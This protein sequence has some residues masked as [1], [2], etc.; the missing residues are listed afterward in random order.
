MTMH[1]TLLLLAAMLL[2]LSLSGGE[3]ASETTRVSR[4]VPHQTVWW[5]RHL[6]P[7]KL[8]E[9]GLSVLAGD[10]FEA[11]SASAKPGGKE[12][13]AIPENTEALARFVGSVPSGQPEKQ[14]SPLFAGRFKNTPGGAGPGPGSGPAPND[15]A[16]WSVDGNYQVNKHIYETSRVDPEGNTPFT[17]Q[18]DS[19]FAGIATY[20]VNVPLAGNTTGD[21]LD[22]C[23]AP[24][25]KGG[26]GS[27]IYKKFI[28]KFE[29]RGEKPAAVNNLSDPVNSDSNMVRRSVYA[30]YSYKNPHSIL[31]P[32]WTQFPRN[33]PAPK[34]GDP[35]A[36]QPSAAAQAQWNQFWNALLVHE[37]GHKAIFDAALPGV[38]TA[39]NTFDK[40]L[41]I[42]EVCYGPG[43]QTAA[44]NRALELA[45]ALRQSEI[46]A[47]VAAV[48]ALR[49]AHEKAQDDY[50]ALTNHGTTQKNADPAAT[51]TTMTVVPLAP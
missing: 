39:I 6:D 48:T 31:M 42:G 32:D 26:A 24:G 30:I 1:P 4:K 44:G 8:Y 19:P 15:K 34:P 36:P 49:N 11:G 37:K 27:F 51:N 21:L 12:T 9:L 25:G 13:W 18:V 14:Y 20:P 41:F 23:K 16:A 33:P 29:S 50:E 40:K 5:A 2:P 22:A 7:A 17:D 35:P 3:A 10:P 38:D 43:Q 46:D 45:Q 47:M 28:P